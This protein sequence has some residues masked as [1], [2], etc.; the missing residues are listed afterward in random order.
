MYFMFSKLILVLQ[1]SPT[2]LKLL[3]KCFLKTYHVFT[4]LSFGLFSLLSVVA[5]FDAV[6][7][8]ILYSIVD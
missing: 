6:V 7:I 4:F 1:E 3:S 2:V 5:V 8:A